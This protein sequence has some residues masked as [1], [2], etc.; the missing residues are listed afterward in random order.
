MGEEAAA[1]AWRAGLALETG[2]S[3]TVANTS[4]RGCQSLMRGKPQEKRPRRSFCPDKA[5]DLAV[6]YYFIL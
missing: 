2:R 6:L 3:G 5:T 4:G 1:I